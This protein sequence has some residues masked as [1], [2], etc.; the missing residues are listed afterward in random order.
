VE[1]LIFLPIFLNRSALFAFDEFKRALAKA[2]LG[3]I[4]HGVPFS[5]DTDTSCYALAAI[6]SQDGRPSLHVVYL[7]RLRKTCPAVEKQATEIIEAV[8]PWSHF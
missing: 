2:S 7:N 6:S 1:Y 5:I 4:R 8:R 3:A